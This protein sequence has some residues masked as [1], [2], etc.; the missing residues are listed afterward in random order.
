MSFIINQNFDLKSPQF[1]FARDYYE[2]LSALKT[3]CG[4][5][6]GNANTEYSSFPN[7]FITNVGGV[8]YQYT[9][10]NSVDTNT[11][12]WRKCEFGVTNTDF[13]NALNSVKD[14]AL[15]AETTA[16]A[17]KTKADKNADDIQVLNGNLANKADISYV[18]ALAQNS[19]IKHDQDNSNA[20]S[21]SLVLANAIEGDTSIDERIEIPAVTEN[22]NGLMTPTHVSNI[23]TALKTA[24]DNKQGI[25]TITSNLDAKL[26]K[27]DVDTTWKANSTNPVESRVIKATLDDVT[28]NLE[29]IST[30]LDSKASK[31]V[32]TTSVDGLLSSADKTKLNNL[33]AD[34]SGTYATKT[35]VSNTYLAKSEI[36]S[37]TNEDIETLWNGATA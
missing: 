7:H 29:N 1:N 23:N 13:Q 5:S 10:T 6:W 16:E 31:D 30:A 33:A 27:S 8:L 34:A 12:K 14:K 4:G 19:T 15:A 36:S 32:A 17:A 25:Q 9:K 11:G 3:A 18:K 20:K 28:G 35:D 24:N 22:L 26:N 21:I 2:S 37:L